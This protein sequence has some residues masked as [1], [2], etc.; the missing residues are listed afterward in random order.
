VAQLA[1]GAGGAF[2]LEDAEP[3]GLVASFTVPLERP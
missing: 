2:L 1:M 3:T